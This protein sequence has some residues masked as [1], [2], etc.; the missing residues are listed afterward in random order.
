MLI[1]ASY[2]DWDIVGQDRK[3]RWIDGFH[4]WGKGC[5]RWWGAKLKVFEPVVVHRVYSLSCSMDGSLLWSENTTLSVLFRSLQ[6]S[7]LVV[8]LGPCSLKFSWFFLGAGFT[9]EDVL[10]EIKAT[11][12]PV[13]CLINWLLGVYVIPMRALIVHNW[14]LQIK[15]ACYFDAQL[16]EV[17]S[18]CVLQTCA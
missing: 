10:L 15:A 2:P 18:S 9:K 3:L 6:F 1:W 13:L 8:V 16:C 17:S 11:C 5:G 7:C 14:I 12:N 4:G